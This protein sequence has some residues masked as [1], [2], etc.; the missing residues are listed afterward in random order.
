MPDPGFRFD[1]SYARLPPALFSAQ[2]PVPVREPRLLL[3]NEPLA[4]RLGLDAAALRQRGAD[5]FGGNALPPGSE[6]IAQAYAGHQFGHATMLG[7]G[8]AILLGEQVAPDGQRFDLVLKGAGRTRYS[9][10]GDGRA[11]LGPVLREYLIS[12]A[13]AALGIPTTRSLA[14]VTTG[15]PV[16]RETPLPGAILTRVARSHLRV[17]SFQY[18]RWLD[19]PGVLPAL[20]AHAIARCHPDLADA[21]D[22][23]LALL[24]RVMERQ[25][26]LVTHWLR[27]GFIHGVMNTDNMTISGETID[28]GPCAFM[29]QYDPATVFSSIDTLGRYAF[30]QQP[31]IALWNLSRLAEALLP[32]IDTEAERAARRATE[33]LDG[34]G[35]RFEA[36]WQRMMAGKLG[37]VD[38]APGDAELC[39]QWLALLKDWQLDYTNAFRA[40]MAPAL[41]GD[42]FYA[43]A[44]F[45]A[46]HARWRP[47]F[48]AGGAEARRR[49]AASNPIVIPRNHRV[50]QALAAAEAGDL[51]PFQQLLDAV[52]APDRPPPDARDTQPPQPSERVLQTFCGT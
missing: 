16:Q 2:A 1:N 38:A 41:P 33:V 51:Q 3:L 20:L 18:A 40:L 23:A 5:W 34:F 15:E 7:D 50:N 46:W 30:G 10:G 12:E 47:R 48:E 27:V 26:E 24:Q 9:R 6:P 13:M 45:D 36:A 35:P 17:G 37:L 8:R 29:D 44:E 11:A 43:S 14:V 39:R 19:E 25:I 4:Q 49:M 28:Y 31:G 42:A 21:A 52:R 22:P 32:L